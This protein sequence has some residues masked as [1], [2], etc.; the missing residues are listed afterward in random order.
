MARSRAVTSPCIALLVAIRGV[1]EES[2]LSQISCQDC[3]LAS[4]GQEQE[5]APHL[6]PL[7]IDEGLC[8][9][10]H[11][12]HDPVGRVLDVPLFDLGC[13]EQT[14]R[15]PLDSRPFAGCKAHRKRRGP[16]GQWRT[17]IAGK[18]PHEPIRTRASRPSFG[19]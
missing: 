2:T 9:E 16:A 1:L 15:A 13:M 12:P 10:R 18:R 19:K 8:H 6:C 5:T 4:L 7:P 11:A 3:S 17:R 14:H